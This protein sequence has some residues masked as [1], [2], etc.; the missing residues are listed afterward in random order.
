MTKNTS[1]IKAI[2]AKCLDCCCNQANEVKLCEIFT[3]ALHPF[4]FGRNPFTNR[5]ISEST[6][7]A[8]KEGREKAKG[9]NTQD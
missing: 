7:Q 5:T 2:R 8:M 6:L 3:C 9:I 1:P 4:R